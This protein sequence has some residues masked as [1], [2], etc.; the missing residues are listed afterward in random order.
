MEHGPRV[1]KGR[2]HQQ[3]SVGNA[4]GSN[5]VSAGCSSFHALSVLELRNARPLR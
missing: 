4:T 2:L 3:V 5:S 1:H